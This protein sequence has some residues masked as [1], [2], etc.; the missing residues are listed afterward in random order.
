[1]AAVSY[2]SD[3]KR[4]QCDPLKKH[5]RLIYR[6]W[7]AHQPG[8][9]EILR[10]YIAKSECDRFAVLLLASDW[11]EKGQR[12]EMVWME[13]GNLGSKSLA[14]ALLKCLWEDEKEFNEADGP[15][16]TEIV[17]SKSAL[18]Q[19]SEITQLAQT[20]WHTARN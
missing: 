20:V 5:E 17:P 8:H 1:M 19:P 4:P 14:K 18:L 7:L 13:A 10:L 9:D 16:F 2:L 12:E 11:M 3:A 15:A 6:A